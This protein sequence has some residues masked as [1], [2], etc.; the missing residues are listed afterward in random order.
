VVRG[1]A[2]GSLSAEARGLSGQR[3]A[4]YFSSR[5]HPPY[6]EAASLADLGD[7]IQVVQAMNLAGRP[8]VAFLTLMNL[9]VRPK[10]S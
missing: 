5:P 3:V 8:S 2:V 4:D 10:K 1:F 9:S 6:E 7:G